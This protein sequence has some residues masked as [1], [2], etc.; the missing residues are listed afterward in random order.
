METQWESSGP[1]L[2][3]RA[4][5]RVAALGVAATVVAVLWAAGMPPSQWLAAI[6]NI[7][8]QPAAAPDRPLSAERQ[9]IA[10]SSL[11]Q[12]PSQAEPKQDLSGTDSSTSAVPLP[13]YLLAVTPGRNS[14]EGSA[15]IG[16]N[17][18]NPQVYAA[19]AILANGARLTEIHDDYVV[20]ARE[21]RVARLYLYDRR[22]VASTAGDDL[23]TVGGTPEAA[24]VKPAS[25]EVLT[26]YLRPSPVYDGEA[27]LGYQVYPGTKSGVFAQLGL[28]PGDMI[29]AVD[30]MPLNEPAQALEMLRQLTDGVVLK[31]SIVRKQSRLQISAD[32]ALVTTDREQAALPAQAF[33]SEPRP[34]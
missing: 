4:L 8:A 6:E 13:L 20:L 15:S 14:A 24:K 17:V 33:A 22:K 11:P 26:D 3:K 12:S 1:E 23:L 19:G 9:A 5:S 2:R 31:L 30:D 21:E 18:D 29:T 10:P 34:L 27:L 28:Q 32:G 16:T 7:F 25:R